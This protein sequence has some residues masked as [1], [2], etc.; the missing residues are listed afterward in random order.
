M[1]N[2]LSHKGNENQM[3][4]I[5]HL[6][7]V[8]MAKIKNSGDSICWQGCRER[9]TLPQQNGYRKCGTFTQWCTYCSAIK[10]T[11]TSLILQVKG[12]N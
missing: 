6:T 4:L 11:M 2:I 12:W 9:G 7:S 5:V 8:R 1:F 10:K 3:T